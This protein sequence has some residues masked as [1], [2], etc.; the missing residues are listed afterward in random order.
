MF[1]P[2]ATG[3]SRCP[4]RFM[5]VR[6]ARVKG[7]LCTPIHKLI[8][9]CVLTGF[10]RPLSLP[11]T[12]WDPMRRLLI[13][14]LTF[15]LDEPNIVCHLY[16]SRRLALDR[17]RW[18]LAPHRRRRVVLH[19][20]LPPRACASG[21]IAALLKSVQLLVNVRM[22]VPSVNQVFP[23]G[24]CAGSDLQKVSGYT[25]SLASSSGPRSVLTASSPTPPRA[26]VNSSIASDLDFETELC[27]FEELAARQC[28]PDLHAE[29]LQDRRA[30]GLPHVASASCISAPPSAS[31][32]SAASPPR[33]ISTP[34][35]SSG[36]RCFRCGGSTVFIRNDLRPCECP[37]AQIDWSSIPGYADLVFVEDS[38]G[39]HAKAS[40][41][42]NT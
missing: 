12:V 11:A 5:R 40:N 24:C 14:V 36:A 8:M 30:G 21:D 31:A 33:A 34:S 29:H 9:E 38:D 37:G 27:L 18:L 20:L 22:S 26:A 35:G 4:L 10:V 28:P 3:L 15:V 23:V 16:L 42:D 17:G 41:D 1:L 25:N 13:S 6:S 39:D 32:G 2:L 19:D 7:S